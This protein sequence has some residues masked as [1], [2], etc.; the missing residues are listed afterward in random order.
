MVHYRNKHLAH[1]LAPQSRLTVLDL[2]ACSLSCAHTILD[3]FKKT[4]SFNTHLQLTHISDSK[5]V[6]LSYEHQAN[7]I[8]HFINTCNVLLKQNMDIN[9]TVHN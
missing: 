9:N 5:A 6:F 8:A 3:R 4:Y 2:I 1:V 7:S